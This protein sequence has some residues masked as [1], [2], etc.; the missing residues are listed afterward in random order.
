[1]KQS[2]VKPVTKGLGLFPDGATPHYMPCFEIEALVAMWRRFADEYEAKG[3]HLEM[4]EA[5]RMCATQ[6]ERVLGLY[7]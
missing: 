1:M 7:A 5:L 2:E 6:A 4:R 3:Q